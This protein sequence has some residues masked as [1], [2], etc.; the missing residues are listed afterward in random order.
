MDGKWRYAGI[1]VVAALAVA[2]TACGGGSKK[3]AETPVGS[4]TADPRPTPFAT[5]LINGTTVTSL[6]GYTAIFPDGWH[7]KANFINTIDSTTDTFFEPAG[8]LQPGQVQTNISVLCQVLRPIPPADFLAAIATRTARLPQNKNIVV[9]RSKVSGIDATVIA[10]S[11]ES[12]SDPNAPKVDK[13]DFVFS[14]DKCDWVITF[15]TAAGD[16]AKYKPQFDGFLNTF[17]LT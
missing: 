14:N 9:S 2:A 17:K 5:P 10:Y 11:S 13:Q 15:T 7:V 1:A 16:F 3:A 12:S 4:V 6:K 8:Q